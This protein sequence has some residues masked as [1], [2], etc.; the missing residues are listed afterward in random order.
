MDSSSKSPDSTRKLPPRNEFDDDAYLLLHPDVSEALRKGIV[1]SAWQHFEL[2]G[3][4]EDRKWVQRADRLKGVSREISAGD[5]MDIGDDTQY[6]D[7][8]VSAIHCIEAALFTARVQEVAI[9]SILD[10]PCGHGRVTRFLKR[11]FPKARLTA[12]DLN[13]EGVEY[14]AA[15]FGAVPVVSDVDPAKIPLEGGYDLI[16]CGSLL[17]HLSREACAAF[18][19]RF[20]SLLAPDGILIFTMHGRRSE[21]EFTS[22]RNRFGLDG[23]R[24]ARLLDEYR[25][26]GFGYVDYESEPGYGISLARPAYV[27]SAMIQNPGWQL[28]GYHESGWDRRQDV[29]ALRRVYALSEG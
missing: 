27:V 9:K 19:Q 15:E 12:C 17:T 13:R 26:T 5:E 20:Q 10:L 23:G 1:G 8:G 29:I 28:I 24:I 11:A 16:W 22:G 6:F 14:C 21:F 2:H 25:R 18:L 7:A 4:A 3:H